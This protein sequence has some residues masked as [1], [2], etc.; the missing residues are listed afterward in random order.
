MQKNRLTIFRVAA[1]AD[2]A[3]RHQVPAALSRRNQRT[4]YDLP[5]LV[6]VFTTLLASPYLAVNAQTGRFI[7]EQATCL[8]AP[9][10]PSAL[11]QT[12]VFNS[13]TNSV[14]GTGSKAEFDMANLLPQDLVSADFLRERFQSGDAELG[15]VD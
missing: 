5:I 2:L 11:V 7:A 8:K 1:L 10:L 13:V 3:A 12:P 6:F 14:S 15:A 4:I 9:I